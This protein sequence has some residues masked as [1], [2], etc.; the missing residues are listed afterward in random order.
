MVSLVRRGIAL[1]VVARRMRV[2]LD[3]VQRWVARAAGQRLDRVDWRNRPPIAHTVQRTSR[4]TENLILTLRRELKEQSALGEFGAVAIRRVLQAQTHAPIPTVRTIGRIL[5]RR[6]AVDHRRRIRRPAPPPGWYLPA[7][8]QG[9]AELDSFDIVEGLLLPDQRAIDVFT[10]IS[11]HGGLIGAWPARAWT[12]RAV[13]ATLV[14]HWRAVGLPA[15]AQFDND[16]RF[17]GPH[18][19]ADV[20]GRV[21]RLCLSLGVVPVF[22]PPREP[23][24]Q[25]AV[26]H[27]NGLWQAKVWGRFAH[28]TLEQVAATSIRYVR[29]HRA[30]AATRTERAPR[31]APF[32]RAWR[33]DLQ[34]P[35]HG[36]V[37]FV[38]RTSE[39]GAVSLLG[40]TFLVDPQWCHRLVR[41]ELLLNEHRI[42]FYALRRAQPE[43]H[44]F[45]REAL[46]R[47]PTRRFKE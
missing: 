34:A 18:Q 25:N 42:R 5:V 8:A 12:A 26:E 4:T 39:R 33:L 41:C 36:R 17:Q 2:S 9:Q 23:G 29:A 38:R 45:L 1:R 3:T 16:N 14:A 13:V 15:Y 46:Y 47:L 19:Y 7:V 32:P 11:L 20:I 21:M 43:A 27:L 22:A 35:L 40:H 10:G 37:V 28:T 44:P 24:F 30:R 6:G 31:R